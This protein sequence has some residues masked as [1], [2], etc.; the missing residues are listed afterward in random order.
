[1]PT[2]AEPTV[3]AHAKPRSYGLVASQ[4]TPNEKVAMTASGNKIGLREKC[5]S[6]IRLGTIK[7]KL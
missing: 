4:Y 7:Q 3:M 2:R 6:S 1:M 5:M